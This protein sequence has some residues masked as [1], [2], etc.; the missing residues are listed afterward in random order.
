MA[1]LYPSLEDMTVGKMVKVRLGE[2]GADTYLHFSSQVQATQQAQ[3]RPQITSGATPHPA[4]ATAPTATGG[5]LYPSLGDYMGLDLKH[6]TPVS[7]TH[8]T[9][10]TPYHNNILTIITYS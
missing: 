4:T 2:E 10:D 9:G 7:I 6:Y 1:G 8:G 5:G 3:T